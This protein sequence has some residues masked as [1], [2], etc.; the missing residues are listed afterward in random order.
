MA[1]SQRKKARAIR[2]IN[3][4]NEFSQNHSGTISLLSAVASI[5]AA[6]GLTLTATQIYDAR[7]AGDGQT[8]AQIADV[9]HQHLALLLKYPE[10]RPF[11]YGRRAL[12]EEE[13]LADQ[14]N[15][16]VDLRLDAMDRVITAARLAGWKKQDLQVWRSIFIR[17]FVDSPTL[18]AVFRS[19]SEDYPELV[20]YAPT[21]CGGNVDL[22]SQY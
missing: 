9:W 8:Y 15:A 17:A 4:V 19:N 2:A 21:Q 13:P 11:I 3:S 18:C 10:M 1:D 7:K 12:K 20:N 5:V 6:L 22:I 14:V 16:Y